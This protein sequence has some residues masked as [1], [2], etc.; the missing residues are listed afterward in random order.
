MTPKQKG[1]WGD[2]V[3][4]PPQSKAVQFYC[5]QLYPKEDGL[6]FRVDHSALCQDYLWLSLIFM[7]YVESTNWLG[8]KAEAS[9]YAALLPGG[10]GIRVV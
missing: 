10:L 2:L 1:Q 5:L 3:M 9:S 6:M 4:E 7:V 8:T